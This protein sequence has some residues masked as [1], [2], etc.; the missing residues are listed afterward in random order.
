M[1]GSPS[2]LTLAVLER[3]LQS[4]PTLTVLGTAF[5]TLCDGITAVPDAAHG[6]VYALSCLGEVLSFDLLN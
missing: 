3:S 2:G 6:K 4:V 5:T 1:A